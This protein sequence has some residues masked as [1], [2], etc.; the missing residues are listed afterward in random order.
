[1][2][3]QGLGRGMAPGKAQETALGMGRARALEKALEKGQGLVLGM[4]RA[5]A[6]GWGQGRA[7]RA[8]RRPRTVPGHKPE[9]RHRLCRHRW[10][11]PQQL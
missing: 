10:R 4:G 5:R 6:R 9:R 2:M 1:M 7:W 8:G 3:A 11:W